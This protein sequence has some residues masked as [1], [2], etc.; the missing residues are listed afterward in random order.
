MATSSQIALIGLVA[1]V[2]VAAFAVSRG[3]RSMFIAAVDV[4]VVTAVL[5]AAFRSTDAQ[6]DRAIGPRFDRA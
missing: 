6:P 5:Y 4:G 3:D 1:V 2:P